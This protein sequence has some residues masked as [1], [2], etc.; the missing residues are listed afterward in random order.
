MKTETDKNGVLFN[1]VMISYANQLN[2]EL[3]ESSFANFECHTRNSYPFNRLF[4]VSFSNGEP[5]VVSNYETGEQFEMKPG[6]LYFFS[7]GFPLAFHFREGTGFFAFHFNLRYCAYQD[8][9]LSERFMRELHDPEFIH[10]LETEFKNASDLSAAFLIKGLLFQ[11]VSKLFPKNKP[12]FKEDRFENYRELFEYIS[13]HINAKLTISHLAE[14]SGTT[15][16]LLSKNFSRDIG[17]PLKKYLSNILL[18]RAELLLRNQEL[19]IRE[20]ARLLDFNDEYYF[21]HF[22]RRQ[23]GLAPGQYRKQQL[24]MFKQ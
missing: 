9:F 22:F 21:S 20:V 5:S 1:T 13:K 18:S 4:A 24:E 23:T 11:K 14:V 15:R 12:L 16:D 7:Y 8:V 2:L 6:Y 10:V 19:T 3:H 17:L